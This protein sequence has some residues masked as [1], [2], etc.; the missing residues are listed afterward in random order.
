MKYLGIPAPSVCSE[1]IFSKAGKIVTKMRQNLDPESV[2]KLGFLHD[3][4]S[5]L[6]NNI[7]F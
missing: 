1:R 4:I 5:L 6:I 3:K 2:E 7:I